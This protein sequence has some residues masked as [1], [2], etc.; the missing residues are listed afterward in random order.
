MGTPQDRP[1][2][3]LVPAPVG[4]L[5]KGTLE[6]YSGRVRPT[7]PERAVIVV[8]SCR[9]QDP[10]R[11]VQPPVPPSPGHSNGHSGPES[12]ARPL[13][14]TTGGPGD[15]VSTLVTYQEP[16]CPEESVPHLSRL[17]PLPPGTEF[18]SAPSTS[19]P[20]HT[21]RSVPSTTDVHRV[22]MGPKTSEGKVEG[23]P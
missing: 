11:Q 14:S 10:V 13:G 12:V 17:R 5:H 6:T 2:L 23:L 4:G 22:V 16:S 9:Q 21:P 3:P 19:V 8:G 7:R 15:S 20:P 1:T 18:V